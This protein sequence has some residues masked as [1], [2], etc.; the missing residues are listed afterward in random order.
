MIKVTEEN[1]KI[2]LKVKKGKDW[3]WGRQ[4]IDWFGKEMIGTVIE[5]KKIGSY[6][7]SWAIVRW[8][9]ET[10]FAY[11]IGKKNYDL[12][13]ADKNKQTQLELEF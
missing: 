8:E 13:L 6:N 12:Y 2:N 1:C 4:N 10:I 9:N 7:V 3:Q 5:I 11:R